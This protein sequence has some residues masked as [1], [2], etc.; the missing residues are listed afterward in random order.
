[1]AGIKRRDFL[2]YCIGSAD[3]LGLDLSVSVRLRHALAADQSLPAVIWLNG[4]NCTGCNGSLANLITPVRSSNEADLLVNYIGPEFHPSLTKAPGDLAARALNQTVAKGFILAV[5]GGIPAAYGGHT[6]PLWAERGHEV[7]AR[8]ALEKLAPKATAI[9]TIGNCASFG[10]IPSGIPDPSG[11]KSI[12]TATGMPTI[13]VPGCP[14]R[15]DRIVWTVAQILANG[16]PFVDKYGRPADIHWTNIHENRPR[17]GGEKTDRFDAE[18]ERL[19]GQA[20]KG[21]G[22]WEVAPLQSQTGRPF[23]A[24]DPP[25]QN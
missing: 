12:G 21:P 1:M 2:K 6:C 14:A 7:T 24:E 9:L 17:N 4:T 3:T 23:M 22:F 8:E 13:N 19:E 15:P 10:G 5:D 18:G 16:S 11:I 25:L 20:C